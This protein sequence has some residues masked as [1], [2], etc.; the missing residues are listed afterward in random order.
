M[1]GLERPWIATKIRLS[2]RGKV[3]NGQA[4]AAHLEASFVSI[5]SG[6]KNVPYMHCRDISTESV[7]YFWTAMQEFEASIELLKVTLSGIK[8]NADR[9]LENARS[10][11]CTVT[12]LANYL[13]RIDKISFRE[14]HGILAEIVAYMN[15]NKRKANEITLQ[16]VNDFCQKL[17]GFSTKMTE[18]DVQNALDPVKNTQSK[19]C[20]GGSAEAEVSRQLSEIEAQLSKDEA[21][22]AAR[23]EQIASAKQAL[24]DAVAAAIA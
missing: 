4:K 14:A 13:V 5:Y 1:C 11:F 10:N 2:R 6:F 23:V 22:T 12:E 15:D 21:V 18:E 17:Y 16:E 9:M 24:E 7:R 20:I 8:V 19:T 3:R